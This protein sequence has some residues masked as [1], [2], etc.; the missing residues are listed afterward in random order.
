M[1]V[2]AGV[3][4]VVSFD[5]SFPDEKTIALFNEAGVKYEKK[6]VPSL[7]ISTLF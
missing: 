2:N 1:I 4:R 6:P 5:T 3:K 7:V